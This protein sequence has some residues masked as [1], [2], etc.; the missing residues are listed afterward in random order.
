MKSDKIVVSVTNRTIFRSILWVVATV[1]A[2]KVIGRVSHILILIFASFFLALALNPVV[3]WLSRRSGIKGRVQATSLAYVLVIAVLAAFF[4]LVTPPLVK[5]TRT[6]INEVPHLVDNFQHQD[7]T[8][9][10]E[11]RKYKLDQ[12][13][14]SS[15]RDF[16]N[17]YGNF[18]TTVWD[19]GKRIAE[20][21][22]SILAV[23]VMTF[24]MLVEGPYWL[25]LYWGIVPASKRA[26]RKDLARQMYKGVSGFVNGQVIIA[27]IA[28]F[29]A[30]LALEI[31][32]HVMDV[33]INAAALAG[34]VSVFGLIPLF[35]NPIA[36]TVVILVCLLNSL[37]LA[38]VM[39]IYFIVYFFVENH[40]FQPFIQSRLNKLTALSVFV[41]ALLGVGL[42]GFLGAIVAIPAASAVK[43]LLEDYFKHKNP[44]VKP[45]TKNETIQAV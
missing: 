17:N 19:T 29:F 30:F 8:L 25:D 5:Q 43:V 18:G 4:I 21:V 11:A 14:S 1:V 42:A 39:L 9:A 3:S 26:H 6:F 12:K 34:I 41:A 23:L 7:S 27:L 44:G 16:A 13:L 38:I 20:I 33:S 10:R 31:A 35:G 2:F 24:M 15:A 45:P 28:G 37:S 22:T 32:S 40:T 36:S